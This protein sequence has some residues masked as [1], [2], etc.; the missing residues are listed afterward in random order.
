M[1]PWVLGK[2]K[3]TC[4][5]DMNVLLHFIINSCIKYLLNDCFVPGSKWCIHFLLKLLRN[6]WLQIMRISSPVVV[7]VK[8]LKLRSTKGYMSLEDIG[9]S[10]FLCPFY[11]LEVASIPWL[12]IYAM[13]F[14]VHHFKYESC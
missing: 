11:L 13:K 1:H 12:V 14:R 3:V 7:E 8:S 6:Q 10:S 5:M 2:Q 4:V 9:R